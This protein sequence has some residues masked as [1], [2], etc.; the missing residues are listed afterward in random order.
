MH[1][2]WMLII[3]LIAGAIAKLILPG[4][5]PS[6]FIMTIVL[7][8]AGSFVGGFLGRMLGV[9]HGGQGRMT[10]GLLGSIVGALILLAL[11]HLFTGRKSNI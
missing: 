2:I 1:I 3:G 9:G 4:K 6:G 10:A 8:L 7:G 11:Y 5:N